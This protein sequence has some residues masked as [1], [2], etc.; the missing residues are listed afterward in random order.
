[1]PRT[2]DFPRITVKDFRTAGGVVKWDH[3]RANFAQG[4]LVWVTSM[5]V[6][7]TAIYDFGL[8]ENNGYVLLRYNDPS[9]RINEQDY[10]IHLTARINNY[11]HKVWT[12]LCPKC[13]KKVR[14]LYYTSGPKFVCKYCEGLNPSTLIRN[15]PNIKREASFGS[16][17]KKLNA[18]N[19]LI[20][21][22]QA[23]RRARKQLY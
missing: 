1:M 17:I 5:G 10:V 18:L 6:K 13:T 7:V 16:P 3:K 2:I 12:F 4:N 11:R 15:L 22:R 14:D 23:V 9:D 8:L 20:K 19:R 21:L